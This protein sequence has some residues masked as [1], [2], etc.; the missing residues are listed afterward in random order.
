V[1]FLV[2]LPVDV[3]VTDPQGRRIGYEPVGGQVI[4]EIPGAYYTGNSG[5]VEFILIGKE[6]EGDFTITTTGT[7]SGDYAVSVHHVDDI[8][9]YPVGVMSG[10]T[11]PGQVATGMIK[12]R[13]TL[14]VLEAEQ[15][16]SNIN[17]NGQAWSL[18][19]HLEGY[20]GTGYLRAKPDRGALSAETET[21]T[22]PEL[23]Y[24]V[25][26]G[27]TGTYYIWLRGAGADGAG[28]SVYVTVARQGEPPVTPLPISGFLPRQWGWSSQSLSGTPTI[29]TIDTPGT[30]TLYLWPREDGVSVD[31]VVLTN[32][33]FFAP[34]GIGP[35]EN[36]EP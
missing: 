28:D 33:A 11:Q 34:V 25:T 3:M 31:R 23:Q 1:A 16:T 32:N 8:D 36:E 13:D 2:H 22:A 19:S 30:Y 12:V 24:E 20:T 6:G 29:L 27:I 21:N 5:D 10:M 14:M 17:R 35:S 26:F 15:F 9:I 4:N 7:G 18:L